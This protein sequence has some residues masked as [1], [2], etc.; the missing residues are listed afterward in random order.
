VVFDKVK[1]AF[2]E[3]EITFTV[4]IGSSQIL[5][6]KRIP[7]R[8]STQGMSMPFRPSLKVRLSI[9]GAG[10]WCTPAKRSSA[11]PNPTFGL[12]LPAAFFSPERAHVELHFSRLFSSLFSRPCPYLS[13]TPPYRIWRAWDQRTRFWE[14]QFSGTTLL[15]FGTAVL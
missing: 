1:Y 14:I 2:D 7:G 8:S 10:W 4:L 15:L 5:L 12:F 9:G 13:F 6:L 3:K 11:W